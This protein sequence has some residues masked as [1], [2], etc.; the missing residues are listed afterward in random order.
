MGLGCVLG[1]LDGQR[2]PRDPQSNS[3]RFSPQAGPT[4]PRTEEMGALTRD[5]YEEDSSDEE[6]GLG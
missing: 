1:P 6:V 3:L 5:E 2:A 4:C